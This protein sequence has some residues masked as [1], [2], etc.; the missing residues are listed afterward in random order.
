VIYET[1][2][3]P[4]PAHDWAAVIKP[5]HQAVIPHIRAHDPDNLIIAGTSSWS[6]DVDEAAADPLAFS[7]VAY[8]LH[9][10]AGTHRQALRDK[11]QRA[12]DLGAAL[13]VTEWG[14]AESNGDGP[15]DQAE[16]QRWWDFMEAN[17]ISYANWSI[18]DKNESTAA[19]R[20]GAAA[21]GGWSD[22]MV[23]PS[24]LLV[25]AQLRVMNS[26]HASH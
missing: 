9:F 22:D 19:L 18:A 4:L 26:A 1:W 21:N 13:M 23:S 10:Y 20:P 12:L 15:L 2:N 5:Y 3:E 6:Q 24:G 16:I 8:T 25:R 17:H 14:T 7:N 11:A